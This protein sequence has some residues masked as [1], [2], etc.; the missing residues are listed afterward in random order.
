MKVVTGVIGN[1]IHVVANRLMDLSLTAAHLEFQAEVRA[2]IADSMPAQMREKCAVD[3]QFSHEEVME[4]HR[5]L[6]GRGWVAP[7]WP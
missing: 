2:F 7:N 3:A 1:D 5:I 6:H 4:W